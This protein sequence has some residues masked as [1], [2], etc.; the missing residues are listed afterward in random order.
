LAAVGEP[1]QSLLE[2]AEALALLTQRIDEPL[3]LFSIA[4]QASEHGPLLA[5]PDKSMN[6]IGRVAFRF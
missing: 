6:H 5:R 3:E 2:G 4:E 1:S